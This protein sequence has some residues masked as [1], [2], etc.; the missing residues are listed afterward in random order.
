MASS[1]ER[2]Q[3]EER[4]KALG[5]RG[6]RDSSEVLCIHCGSPFKV[7]TSTGGEYGICQSCID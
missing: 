3:K 5:L 2:K 1:D 6:E 4:L 7:Y